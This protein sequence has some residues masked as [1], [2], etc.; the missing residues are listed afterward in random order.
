MDPVTA[1][2]IASIP[3]MLQGGTGIAQF[4]KGDGIERR[5]Q[6]PE[7]KIPNEIYESLEIATRRAGD[8]QL[9]GEGIMQD[10]QANTTAQIL[11][12][13]RN[14]DPSSAAGA[15][16][17]IDRNA[18]DTNRDMALARSQRGDQTDKDLMGM[19]QTMANYKDKVFEINRLG[20]FQDDAAAS[21]ALQGAG[22]QNLFSGFSNLSSAALMGGMMNPGSGIAL[23]DNKTQQQEPFAAA[24]LEMLANQGQ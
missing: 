8:R 22:M 19:L 24:L 13:L 10:Q 6:R 9:P 23:G 14:L 12:S 21:S 5:N 1:T 17:A 7:Y 2:L 15:I 4:L 20:K 11:E 16:G 18:Q 3:A